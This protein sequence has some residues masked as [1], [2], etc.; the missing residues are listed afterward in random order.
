MPRVATKTTTAPVANVAAPNVVVAPKEKKVKSS[1]PVVKTDI[2]VD[3]PVVVEEAAVVVDASSLTAK[4]ADYSSKIQQLSSVVSLLKTEYKQLEKTV[5]R[6]LKNAQKFA[7]KKKRSSGNRAPSG[8]VKPTRISDELALFLGKEKG[9]ELAR[10]AVSKEINAYIRA[11]SLQDKE[12]GRKIHADVKLAKL[13]K[14]GKE[15][16]LTYFNLQKYMKNHFIKAVPAV[17]PVV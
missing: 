2:A 5:A 7:S 13:L 3:A 6:E 4:L 14:L 16:E 11:N 17:V 9:T 1:K 12:N 10:T 8:F 15:D